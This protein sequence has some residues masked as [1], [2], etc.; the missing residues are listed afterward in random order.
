MEETS[1]Q[2]PLS[3]WARLKT[4]DAPDLNQQLEKWDGHR[5]PSDKTAPGAAD[6][7]KTTTSQIWD[8]NEE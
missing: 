3:G 7:A 5:I 8:K 2:L 1:S 4:K 6:E